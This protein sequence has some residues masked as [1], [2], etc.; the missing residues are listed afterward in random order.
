MKCHGYAVH[1]AEWEEGASGMLVVTQATG[2]HDAWVW[3]GAGGGIEGGHGG[4]DR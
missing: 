2:G 3:A 1:A 4:G